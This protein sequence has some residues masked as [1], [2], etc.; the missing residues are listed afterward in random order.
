LSTALP[1]SPSD[2]LGDGALALLV[3]PPLEPA[4][5]RWAWP[6]AELAP[7]REPARAVIS[8]RATDARTPAQPA[9]EPS[10]HARHVGAWMDEARGTVTLAGHEAGLAGRVDLAAGRAEVRVEPGSADPQVLEL[11]VYG[12]VWIASALLLGRQRRVMVH[13]AAVVAP[14]GGAW[15]LAADTHGGKTSTCVNLIRAGCDYLSDD[16]VVIGPGAGTG[17]LRVAGWPRRFHLDEG[18]EEG[19]SAGRRAPVDPAR[20]GPGRRCAAAPLAGV[21]LP[22]IQ[23][24]AP[25]RAAPVHATVALGR[26]IRHSPWLLADRAAAPPLLETMKRVAGLPAFELVLGRDTYADPAALLTRLPW[27]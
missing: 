26:L 12:A 4:L 22:R 25:T 23:A 14:D 20:Y 5:E 11:A 1:P 15:L 24:D 7:V 2:L 13:A 16:H 17:G 27:G 3:D 18:F 6:L 9:G 8:V 10:F 21:L 19:R